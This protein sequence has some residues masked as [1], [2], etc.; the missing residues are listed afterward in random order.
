MLLLTALAAAAALPKPAPSDVEID[1]LDAEVTHRVFF[2]IAINR[3]PMGRIVMGLFGRVVPKTVANFVSLCRGDTIAPPD[4]PPQLAGKVMTYKNVHF[5]RI[6][7][8]FIC[9][10]GDI[11]TMKYGWSYSIYGQHFE[12]E[13]FAIKHTR[14][15]LL[16]LANAGKDTNGSQFSMMVAPAHHLDGLHVVFGRI[17]EGF[18]LVLHM[19][20]YGTKN[21][22]GTPKAEVVIIDCGELPLH[23]AASV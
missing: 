8:G 23:S 16:S 2:D 1:A 6:V 15:G 5:Q 19:N 12:D 13:S 9:Q 7:P 3:K 14:G 17:L 21:N 10:T 18:D 22:E 4:A 11:V 20:Q